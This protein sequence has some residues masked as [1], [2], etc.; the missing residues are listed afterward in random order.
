MAY[1]GQLVSM[2]EK[3]VWAIISPDDKSLAD[4]KLMSQK[5]SLNELQQAV[6]G[7]IEAIPNSWIKTGIRTMYVNEEGMW[8]KLPPNRLV[9]ELLDVDMDYSILGP[10]VVQ[11]LPSR[12]MA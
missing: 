8:E 10:V 1:L 7:N 6:G 11:W 12:I 5:P 3:Y 4:A 2:A 9:Q